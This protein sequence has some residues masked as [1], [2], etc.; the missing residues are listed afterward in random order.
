M[1]DRLPQ[2]PSLS[3][4][5]PLSLGAPAP[6]PTHE[7]GPS[8]VL[9]NGP[10]IDGYDI[11]GQIGQGG[12]GIVYRARQKGLGRDVAIKLLAGGRLGDETALARFQAEARLAA[13]LHHPNIVQIFEFGQCAAGPF[14]VMELINGTTL[15]ARTRNEP[16]T[17][18]W[19]AELIATLSEAVGFAHGRGVVH[20]DLKPANVLIAA[21]GGV[22]LADFGLAK[23]LHS[24]DGPTR[25]GE[26]LGTPSYMAPEQASG[27]ISLIGPRTDIYSLG[28]MLYELLTGSPPFRGTD[29]V[30]VVLAVLSDDPVRPQSLISGIPRDLQTIC[31]KCLQKSPRSRYESAQALADDLRRFLAGEPIL[32]S[33]PS[34]LARTKRWIRRRPAAAAMI[35]SA[36]I[37]AGTFQ[38]YSTHKNS[39][40]TA[41]LSDTQRVLERS[42]K[43]VRA[44]I[45]AAD[46]RVRTDRPAGGHPVRSGTRILQSDS[47]TARG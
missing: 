27:A 20:R 29:P 17:P 16:Q 31:L 47:A 40:L 26:I 36:V 2:S 23:E 35:A 21:E 45:E 46:R 3:A 1:P 13:G 37:G 12:M 7:P 9:S 22:K 8:R 11:L 30:A 6:L 28:A 38:A 19:S 4:E 32:A 33:P 5:T 18:R 42:E 24:T 25:S 39:Q 43:N 10:Q 14:I 44:A 41:A 15:S 34:M